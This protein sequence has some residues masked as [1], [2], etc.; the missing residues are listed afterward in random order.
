MG[1]HSW[2][3]EEPRKFFPLNV[4]PYTGLEQTVSL[5]QCHVPLC[6]TMFRWENYEQSQYFPSEHFVLY[7]SC[8]IYY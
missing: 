8:L 6:L 4:L 2:L 7:G 5:E 3:G 1:K